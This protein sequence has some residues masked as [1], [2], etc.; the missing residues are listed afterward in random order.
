MGLVVSSSAETPA[1]ENKGGGDRVIGEPY[2]SR[3]VVLGKNG[4]VATSHPLASQIAID[5]L[6]SGGNAVDAAIA[7]NAALG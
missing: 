5:I 7:A 4:M 3:S 6:K 2:A 1:G